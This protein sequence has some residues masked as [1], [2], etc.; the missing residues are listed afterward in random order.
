MDFNE[1]HYSVGQNGGSTGSSSMRNVF[2]LHPVT[3]KRPESPIGA[4]KK[5]AWKSSFSV[6]RPIG[7]L[8]DPCRTPTGPPKPPNNNFPI[9][10]FGS[11]SDRITCRA[12]VQ[13]T[14][15]VYI[16]VLKTGATTRQPFFEPTYRGKYAPLT[17][18][19]IASR[20]WANKSCEYDKYRKIDLCFENKSLGGGEGSGKYAEI[21]YES[22][23]PSFAES[24]H[25]QGLESGF[26]WFWDFSG[27]HVITE[28][29]KNGLRFSVKAKDLSPA[30]SGGFGFWKLTTTK[31]N[32]EQHRNHG[33]HHLL[34]ILMFFH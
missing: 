24:C 25:G 17:N 3:S 16:R 1:T 29:R 34:M 10:M 15:R 5:N 7:P 22:I 21:L 8:K 30:T 4:T 20:Y 9:S 14:T 28:Y 23:A 33:F 32:V 13:S 6:F 11:K 26:S 2:P 27:S 12:S 19:T 18:L 31:Q